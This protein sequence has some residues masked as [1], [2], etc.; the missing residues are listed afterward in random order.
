[1][2]VLD[3]KVT[4]P[5]DEGF[6]AAIGTAFGLFEKVKERVRGIAGRQYVTCEW[7][8]A[9]AEDCETDTYMVEDVAAALLGNHDPLIT[10]WLDHGFWSFGRQRLRSGT[11]WITFQFD[12]TNHAVYLMLR[13]GGAITDPEDRPL[14]AALPVILTTPDEYEKLSASLFGSDEIDVWLLAEFDKLTCTIIVR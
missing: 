10:E 7:I 14:W 11:P 4:V 12:K 8:S 1:M 2:N 5:P 6:R 3:L 13:Y 9:T